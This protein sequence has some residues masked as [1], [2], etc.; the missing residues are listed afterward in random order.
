MDAMAATTDVIGTPDL[1][2]TMLKSAA[3]LCVVLAVLVF[4][5]FIL[6]R[7]VY[8]GGSTGRSNPIKILATSHVAPKE[9]IVLVD[10]MGERLLLG[11][12]S[13]SIHTLA[14][15]SGNAETESPDQDNSDD[16]HSAPSSSFMNH[17]KLAGLSKPP[18]G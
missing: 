14:K 18:R 8:Q 3:M 9:R 7:F 16:P 15:I 2:M 6:R 17:L 13:Q 12:T 1:W 11:V 5:V 4:F 10:V